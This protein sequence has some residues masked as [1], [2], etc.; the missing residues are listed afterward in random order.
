MLLLLIS[1]EGASVFHREELERHIDRAR[2]LM[3]EE[4]P[5]KCRYLGET[6]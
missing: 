1:P 5:W 3:P 2:G 4:S 6:R